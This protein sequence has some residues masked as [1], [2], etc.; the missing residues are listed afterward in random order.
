MTH[1][2]ALD[3]SSATGSTTPICEKNFKCSILFSVLDSRQAVLINI[4]IMRVFQKRCN[5]LAKRRGLATMVS[6]HEHRLDEHDQDIATLIKAIP[7]LSP[8]EPEPRPIVGFTPPPINRWRR[9]L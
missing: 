4:T 3:S 2:S 8:P 9:S 7:Q 6:E 5:L 1:S